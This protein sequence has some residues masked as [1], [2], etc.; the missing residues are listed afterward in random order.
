MNLTIRCEKK[1]EYQ[2]LY[3]FV[4]EVF[5]TAHISDGDEQEFVNQLR[6]S[7][8]YIPELALVALD[9]H[10]IIGHIMLTNYPLNG[11][12]LLAPLSIDI[13]YRKKGV[14]TLLVQR[15]LTLAKEMNYKSVL[16]LGDPN[17]YSRFGFKPS[18]D[19]GIHCTNDIPEQYV[20]LLEL[21]ENALKS[22]VGNITF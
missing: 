10:Q 19:F 13:H 15:A 11:M 3:H 7:K 4:K 1:S 2:Y 6:N 16:V 8:N 14:G 21:E 22:V 17:Y 9:N 18:I 20:Q 12:L 5:K